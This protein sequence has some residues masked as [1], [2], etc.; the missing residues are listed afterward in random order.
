MFVLKNENNHLYE[1]MR[2]TLYSK[3]Y[4]WIDYSLTYFNKYLYLLLSSVPVAF[5][6][7]VEEVGCTGF[8]H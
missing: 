5:A 4:K 6:D 3:V 8:G 1:T 7:Y 2:I